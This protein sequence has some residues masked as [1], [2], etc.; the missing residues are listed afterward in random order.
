M[1]LS[2]RKLMRSLAM[3]PPAFWLIS[4]TNGAASAG[5]TNAVDVAMTVV[6]AGITEAP[7]ISAALPS[8]LPP[9]TLAL[10]TNG[11][12]GYLD[13]A[14]ADLTGLQAQM[15]TGISDPSGAQILTEVEQYFNLA[16]NYLS[17]VLTVIG[18]VVPGVA[19]AQAIV[20]DMV[21]AAPLIEDFINAA[22]P[23]PVTPTVASMKYAATRAS[24]LLTKG[25][26]HLSAQ[27]AYADLKAKLRSK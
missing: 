20:Q 10:I 11:K 7:L 18:S 6:Q 3:M 17:P 26:A 21:L 24:A 9:T 22:I 23:K 12:T 27:A 5:L 25:L 4:C 8:L 13:M 1:R 2:R 16:L 14:L 15:A 19:Q